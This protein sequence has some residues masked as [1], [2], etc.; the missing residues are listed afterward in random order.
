MIL[1][2]ISIKTAVEGFRLKYYQNYK[3]VAIFTLPTLRSHKV[4]YERILAHVVRSAIIDLKK[5]DYVGLVV[6]LQYYVLPMIR[7]IEEIVPG[8]AED[9]DL[10]FIYT[11][12]NDIIWPY[13]LE[14]RQIDHPDQFIPDLETAVKSLSEL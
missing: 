5:L 2:D 10:K 6:N 12:Y 14:K 4:I 7:D 11:G 1:D 13:F 3:D 9:F 8:I